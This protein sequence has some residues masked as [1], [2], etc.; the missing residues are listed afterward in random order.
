[1][2]LICAR[3]QSVHSKKKKVERGWGMPTGS[4]HGGAR[5]PNN[6][7]LLFSNGAS[8]H[9]QALLLQYDGT[10]PDS[11]TPTVSFFPTHFAP[12]HR[13]MRHQCS[14]LSY[15]PVNQ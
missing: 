10:G 4:V 5:V 6:D 7:S 3:I 14:Y 2:G 8:K 13:I 11:A 15:R 1:M 9:G 12:L